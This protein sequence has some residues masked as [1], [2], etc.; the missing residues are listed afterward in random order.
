MEIQFNVWGC[1]LILPQVLKLKIAFKANV[2]KEGMQLANKYVKGYSLSSV[3]G[4]MYIE[5]KM[6]CYYTLTGWLKW[7]DN[8][9]CHKDVEM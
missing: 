3:I 6:R 4:E 7:K 9:K 5:T 2:L 8:Q 1:K